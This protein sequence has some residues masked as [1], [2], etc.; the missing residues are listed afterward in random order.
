ML[1]FPFS[2]LLVSF[3]AGDWKFKEISGGPCWAAHSILTPGKMNSGLISNRTNMEE[4]YKEYSLEAK[5]Y[6][7]SF[8]YIHTS[9]LLIHRL[10]KHDQPSQ[11]TIL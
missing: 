9:H 11:D 8:N 10:V 1:F 7:P 3:F 6:I 2:Q 5:E 4:K